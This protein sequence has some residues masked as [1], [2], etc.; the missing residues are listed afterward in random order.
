MSVESP[1]AI[2]LLERNPMSTNQSDNKAHRDAV[3]L[4]EGQ[5]QVS[6][7]AAGAN[8]ATA[9]AAEI[10]FYRACISSAKTN[11]VPVSHY[12]EALRSLGL[13]S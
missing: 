6:V 2:R 1:A 7:A 8:Q 9:L 3:N 5:R 10:V 13:W 12:T 11:G 4:A